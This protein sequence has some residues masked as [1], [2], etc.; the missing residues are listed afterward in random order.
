MLKRILNWLGTSRASRTNR[1]R[2][3]ANSGRRVWLESLEVRRLLVH[4]V[5]GDV[6]SNTFWNDQAD[7]IYRLVGDVTVRSGGTLT[8]APNITVIGGSTI[9][10]GTDGTSGTLNANGAELNY[11]HVNFGA[12]G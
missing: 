8:I 6:T 11:Y 3:Q 7:P 1:L 4:D 9:R 2:R 12:N 5:S 10:V